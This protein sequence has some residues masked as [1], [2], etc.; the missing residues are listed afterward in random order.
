M[1]RFTLNNPILLRNEGLWGYYPPPVQYGIA[2]GQV[3]FYH[4]NKLLQG[5]HLPWD[6]KNYWTKIVYLY[7]EGKQGTVSN[8]I[9]NGVE[10][11]FYILTGETIK[12]IYRTLMVVTGR[13]YEPATM[14]NLFS[15]P[16]CYILND[17]GEVIPPSLSMQEIY[18]ILGH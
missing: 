9:T 1:K 15:K 6:D 17:Q 14:S 18:S 12:E 5:L 8:L 10:W 3:N 11:T 13:H 16:G 4:K 7:S 2:K